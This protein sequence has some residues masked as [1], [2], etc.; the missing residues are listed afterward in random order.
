M[1][2]EINE[3]GQNKKEDENEIVLGIDFGTTNSVIASSRDQKVQIVTDK[4]NKQL[5]QSLFG[6]VDEKIICGNE[7]SLLNENQISSIKRIIGRKRKDIENL[8]LPFAIKCIKDDPFVAIGDEI[9]SPTQIT[10][11]ILTYLKQLA[12]NFFNSK[13]SKTVITVP[14]YY[15]EESRNETRKAAKLAGF[16]VLRLISEP[17]AAAVAYGLDQV[18]KE[19]KFMVFDLGGGTFDI[20][21]INLKNNIFKVLGVGGDSNLGGDDFDE[22]ILQEITKKLNLSEISLTEKIQLKEVARNIKESLKTKNNFEINFRKKSH[23]FHLSLEDFNHLCQEKILLIKKTILDLISELKIN[24]DDL[25]KIIL[26]GG[27]SRLSLVKTIV[28]EIFDHS[29][30]FD[31]LD[32][33]K[34]VAIGAAKQAESLTTAKNSLLLDVVPLSLGIETMGG[35]VEKIIDRNSTVPIS[36][37]KKFTTYIDGQTKIK[38]NVVQG[39]RELSKDC[40]SLSEFE[41]T[42]I[43]PMKAGMV[44]ILITFMI[45]A[46]GILTVSVED[47][48]TD[49]KKIV[50][51]NKTQEIDETKIKNILLESLKKSKD[52]INNR[53][54][55]ETKVEAQQN[56]DIVKRFIKEDSHLLKE[57]EKEKILQKMHNLENAIESGKLNLLKNKLVEFN[58]VTED[59][60]NRRIS[61]S[62]INQSKN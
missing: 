25:S 33:D 4:K 28:A 51:I 34:I 23:K 1:V 21:I 18:K 41:I 35:I 24:K 38:I 46:D 47:D 16:D 48:K 42:D 3:P 31:D 2:I 43:P 36:I 19:E 27:S 40:I 52:D 7:V 10:A 57:K 49:N 8:N 62:I 32:P 37:T 59:F 6:V 50:S 55:I 44:K 54:F 20:S 26:V 30:I 58:E 15:S 60:A 11:K 61:D 53:M 56:I 5:H 14:A 45:D 13:I 17:T 22:I 29:Q 39:E 12:E 9:F